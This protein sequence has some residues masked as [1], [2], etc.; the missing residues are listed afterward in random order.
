MDI[1]IKFPLSVPDDLGT[2]AEVRQN[3]GDLFFRDLLSAKKIA[4]L[5]TFAAKHPGSPEQLSAMRE[6]LK[7][8]IKL[9]EKAM[10][11]KTIELISGQADHEAV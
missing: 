4:L 5:E 6:T 10:E 3:L 8:E 9:I 2:F 1:L 7:G 11:M